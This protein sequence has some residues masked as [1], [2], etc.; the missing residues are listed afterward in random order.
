MTAFNTSVGNY[1]TQPATIHANS[2]PHVANLQLRKQL[3]HQVEQENHL[4]RA[5]IEMQSRSETFEAQFCQVVPK[6]WRQC[7]PSQANFCYSFI[8]SY[9]DNE[10]HTAIDSEL[11]V[12]WRELSALLEKLDPT[13]EW[14]HFRKFEH[15]FLDPNTPYRDQQR[16]EYPHHEH[17]S[18][19]AVFSGP[20]SRKKRFTKKYVEHYFVLTPT[21]Y[22]HQYAKES[23][24]ENNPVPQLSLYLPR[25][26]ITTPTGNEETAAAHEFTIEPVEGEKHPATKTGGIL[27]KVGIK[28]K[29]GYLIRARTHAQ[30]LEWHEQCVA[31]GSKHAGAAAAGSIPAAVRSAGYVDEE[32]EEESVAD[33]ESVATASGTGVAA[34][35]AVGTE[36]ETAV[37]TEAETETVDDGSSIEEEASETS[38]IA[39]NEAAAAT[40]A[41]KTGDKPASAFKEDFAE[42][43]PLKGDH[44]GAEP[45]SATSS[46][47]VESPT[48]AKAEKEQLPAYSTGPGATGAEGFP[49]D[50]KTSMLGGM[51]EKLTGK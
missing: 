6:V 22:L 50:K 39:E 14:T 34:P 7:K 13:I 15:L 36:G 25:C 11:Q 19:V 24:L 1:G 43:A 31:L 5:T 49:V 29:Q 10:K 2:D 35:A 27:T 45:A 40:G 17:E 23:D 21:G 12:Q 30:A 18:T 48:S 26:E 16:I 38:S 41:T 3:K 33:T 51:F 42:E 20:L 32:E 8:N 28:P 4:Q 9:L 46:H 44:A 47:I 37:G